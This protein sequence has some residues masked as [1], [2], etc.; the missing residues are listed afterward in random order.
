MRRNIE[1]NG[2]LAVQKVT[3]SVGDARLACLQ[4]AGTFDAVD[5]DPYGSPA[6]LL[7]AAVQVGGGWRRGGGGRGRPGGCTVTDA[8]KGCGTRCVVDCGPPARLARLW[9]RAACCW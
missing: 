2:P 8:V 7:D 6:Q 9:Q 3:P 5:L 1:F 4:G